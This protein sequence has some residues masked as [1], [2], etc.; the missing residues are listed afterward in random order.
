MTRFLILAALLAAAP[1]LPQNAA[2]R[3]QRAINLQEPAAVLASCPAGL[4]MLPARHPWERSFRVSLQWAR[5]I[6]CPEAVAADDQ[7]A[8]VAHCA[9]LLASAPEWARFA[10]PLGRAWAERGEWERAAEVAERTAG[11]P[12]VHYYRARAAILRGDGERARAELRRYVELLPDG[13]FAADAHWRLADLR[14]FVRAAASRDPRLREAFFRLG[15][16][17]A[18]AGNC[19]AANS[20]FERFAARA[21]DD[22]RNADVPDLIAECAAP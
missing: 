15:S 19:E 8:V 2:S 16:A 13:E 17:E 11:N 7:A 12:D 20:W 10:F 5:E 22:P 3:C 14:G 1:A 9:P 6:A 4:D 18:A 21:P